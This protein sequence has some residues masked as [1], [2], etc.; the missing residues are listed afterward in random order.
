MIQRD[1]IVEQFIK[2]VS[3]DSPSL[4]EK[5]MA[6]YIVK[7][8]RNRGYNVSVDNAAD[9]ILGES[10]NVWLKITGTSKVDP[11]LIMAHMDTVDP[12]RNKKAVVNGEYITSDGTTV[13]GG[14]DL[15]GVTV[16]LE[17]LNVLEED[18]ISHGDIYIVFT[19]AEE[20]GLLGAKNFDFGALGVKYGFVLDGG[21]KIG[22]VA[23]KAPSHV[24][25]DINIKGKSAHAGME[26][27]NGIS[28]IEVAAH[29]I[30][31]MKLG[32]IDIDTTANIGKISG[33]K[34]TNIVCDNVDIKAEAR[35]LCE[36]KLSR[37]VDHMRKTLDIVCKEY[38]AKLSIKQEYEYHAYDVSNEEDLIGILKRAA[39]LSDIE[40]IL[41]STGGGSDTNVLNSVGI[42]SCNISIGMDKVHTVHERIK[43][44]DMVDSTKF[45]ISLVRSVK[46][47]GRE[48]R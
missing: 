11:I 1:R 45:L 17:M 12:S 5:D 48:V 42:P 31:R 30:S 6:N 16:I 40:L 14:D 46:Q 39:D 20:I 47:K 44:S 9:K 19:V 41:E 10:G 15:A 38:G 18:K 37:Q 13:L 3:I 21:G 33:G 8:L 25:L 32:R 36:E 26:P 34:A 22:R 4:C 7:V 43:I 28:A 2:L 27:E 29:A 35:S 23:I 24:S